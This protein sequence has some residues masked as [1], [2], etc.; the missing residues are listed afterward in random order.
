[1]HQFVSNR[2]FALTVVR[3]HVLPSVTADRESMWNSSMVATQQ[4]QQQQRQ[5]QQ[6]KLLQRA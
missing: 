5:Q 6:P 4:Q 2:Y 1:V 3:L